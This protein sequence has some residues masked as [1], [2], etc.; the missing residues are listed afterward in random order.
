MDRI[1]QNP[2]Q[3][4]HMDATIG[5][6]IERYASPSFGMV[7][8]VRHDR[9][10]RQRLIFERETGLDQAAKV[11]EQRAVAYYCYMGNV[12]LTEHQE[13]VTTMC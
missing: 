10:H 9:R 5:Q 2:R 7:I 1:V 4:I 11:I 6:I 12:Q 3:L 13:S 8:D